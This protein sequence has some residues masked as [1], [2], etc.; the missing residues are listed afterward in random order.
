M[1]TAHLFVCTQQFC[2]SGLGVFVFVRRDV[3]WHV[4]VPVNPLLWLDAHSWLPIQSAGRIKKPTA[5]NL[6]RLQSSVQTTAPK[7]RLEPHTGDLAILRSFP[8][9]EQEERSWDR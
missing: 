1:T 8:V 4:L 2:L 5:V 9:V 7:H 3:L 6:R